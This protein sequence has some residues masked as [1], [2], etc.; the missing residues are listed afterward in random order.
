METQSR[1]SASVNKSQAPYGQA[2]DQGVIPQKDGRSSLDVSDIGQPKK[3][4][5]RQNSVGNRQF[6][7]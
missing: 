4:F 7:N 6:E 2:G 3:A 1:R 5:L